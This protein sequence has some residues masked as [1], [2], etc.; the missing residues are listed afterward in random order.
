MEKKLN[1]TIVNSSNKWKKQVLD[2]EENKNWR[3]LS[4]KISI[5]ILRYLRYEKKNKAWLADKLG[6][7]PQYISRLTS[8]KENLSLKSIALLQDALEEEI[9]SIKNIDFSRKHQGSSF[10]ILIENHCIKDISIENNNFI[11]LNNVM[12]PYPYKQEKYDYR[13]VIDDI[14]YTELIESSN[15]YY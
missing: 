9:I 2:Y 15:E 5:A 11:Q 3:I 14:E 8:G 10:Y 13:N 12:T 4:E 7:S 1:Y 6:K